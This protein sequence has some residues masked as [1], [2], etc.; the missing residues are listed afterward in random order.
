MTPWSTA[1]WHMCAPHAEC[2]CRCRLRC[3]DQPWLSDWS[4]SLWSSA[5][6]R[7]SLDVA[8]HP[9]LDDLLRF[10]RLSSDWSLSYSGSIEK[11]Y[12]LSMDWNSVGIL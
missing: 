1:P 6:H 3:L 10:H 5:L 9:S 7:W 12:M 11:G 4:A 8:L 2:R